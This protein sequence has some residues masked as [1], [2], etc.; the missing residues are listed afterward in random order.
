LLQ[1]TSLPLCQGGLRCVELI[2][3][4]AEGYGADG[5]RFVGKGNKEAIQPIVDEARAAV[6]EWL[7]SR[8]SASGP[9]MYLSHLQG[10]QDS[11]GETND[12]GSRALYRRAPSC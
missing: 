6:D 11:H 9:L 5:V 12:R 8:G 10:R 1:H 4:D 2:S 3:V 7:A